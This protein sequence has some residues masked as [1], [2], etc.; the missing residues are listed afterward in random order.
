MG[1]HQNENKL[2]YTQQANGILGIRGSGTLL[3]TL[4]QD[5]AHVNANIFSMCLAEWGGRLVVGGYNA[6]YHA[7]QV[8]WIGVNPSSY[9]VTLSQMRVA[10]GAVISNFRHA[11]VDSGTTYTY[12]GRGPYRALKSGIE[13]YCRQHNSCRATKQGSNCWSIKGHLNG[14]RNFPKIDVYFGKT[15]TH[16]EPRS[17]LYRKGTGT[18]YCYSFEDDGPGAG[19]VLGAS[20]M[21]YHEVI[22]DLD[23]KRLGIVD[24]NC[25]EYRKRPEHR[26]S[27]LD[28]P[29][30]VMPS[31]TVKPAAIAKP[32][33]QPIA[34]PA[35]QPGAAVTTTVSAH[36][37]SGSGS[38]AG[39]RASSTGTVTYNPM[40]APK[41]ASKG[42][43]K[44]FWHFTRIVVVA[45]TASVA[46]GVIVYYACRSCSSPDDD[47]EPKF[48]PSKNG[49]EMVQVVG[50]DAAERGNDEE[51]EGLVERRDVRDGSDNDSDGKEM[52]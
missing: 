22:F 42:K 47:A 12:M 26:S 6:S 46:V 7:G 14:L 34:K 3:R 41:F 48:G 32:A 4:F 8:A 11:M 16:W 15:L 20:W 23:N 37:H 49:S 24:A 17:Y 1:C 43:T 9:S 50:S 36:A 19:T 52:F 51:N 27:D 38:T 39:S 44:S 18:Q 28:L 33:N 30:T 35:K 21:L 5:K 45:T 2:F 25:P 13:D 40:S 10:G 29:K 31:P